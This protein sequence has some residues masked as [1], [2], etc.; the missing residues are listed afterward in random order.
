VAKKTENLFPYS[1]TRQ[2]LEQL[3]E[4]ILRDQGFYNMLYWDYCSL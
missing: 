4:T 2:M 3:N 1:L